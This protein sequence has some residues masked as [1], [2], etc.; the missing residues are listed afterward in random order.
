[1]ATPSWGPLGYR[2]ETPGPRRMLALDGGGIRGLLSLKVLAAL[3]QKLAAHYAQPDFRLCHFFDYIAGTSTGAITAAA[4]ARGLRVQEIVEFYQ[5]YGD[6][7][8]SKRRWGIWNSLYNN[9][10]LQRRLQD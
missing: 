9:G 5:L 3:E 6:E 7:I 2:F 1:M 8:F 10:P 4:L